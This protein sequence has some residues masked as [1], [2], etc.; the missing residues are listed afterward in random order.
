MELLQKGTFFMNFKNNIYF[1]IARV[2]WNFFEL[3]IIYG[4]FQEISKK[5]FASVF[6]IVFHTFL[7]N[8]IRLTYGEFGKNMK[9]AR[10]YAEVW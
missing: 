9:N 5:K 1:K 3:F 10:D 2:Y 4:D 7:Q 6:H 8:K